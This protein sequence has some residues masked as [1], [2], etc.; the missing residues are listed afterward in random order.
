M[1]TAIG[2][3]FL[4]LNKIAAAVE[5]IL[6]DSDSDSDATAF[7]SI[8]ASLGLRIII[9]NGVFVPGYIY[10]GSDGVLKFYYRYILEET[11]ASLKSSILHGVNDRMSAMLFNN[12]EKPVRVAPAGSART[13][14]A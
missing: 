6:D 14:R 11:N 7:K 5:D 4:S 2:G 1:T 12:A 9:I 13:R 10:D 3:G 8:V